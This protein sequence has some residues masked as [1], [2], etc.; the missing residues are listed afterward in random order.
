MARMPCCQHDFDPRFRQHQGPHTHTHEGEEKKRRKER[1]GKRH[2]QHTCLACLRER[3]FLTS[4]IGPYLALLLV[5]VVLSRA[6]PPRGRPGRG[7][8]GDPSS[9]LLM[10]VKYMS[11][12][13]RERQTDRQRE[14]TKRVREDKV[15]RLLGSV[16]CLSMLDCKRTCAEN[17]CCCSSA[18]LPSLKGRAADFCRENITN[19]SRTRRANDFSDVSVDG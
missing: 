10:C 15:D 17:D 12:W 14:I 18:G 19:I 16:D 13:H 6:V 7:T 4:T 9:C 2:T 3:V 11:V 1:E 5:L 8:P